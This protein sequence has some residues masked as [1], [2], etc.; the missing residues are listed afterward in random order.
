MFLTVER[1]MRMTGEASH[2]V[3]SPAT[4]R[5]SNSSLLPSEYAYMVESSSDLPKRRGRLRKN[6]LPDPCASS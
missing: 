3:S 4:S 2:R 1:S 5:P 6:V